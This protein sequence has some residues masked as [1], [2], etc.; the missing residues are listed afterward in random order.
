MKKRNLIAALCVAAVMALGMALAGCSAAPDPAEQIKAD[1]A[2]QF[3]PV[4]NLDQAAIDE[5]TADIEAV[6][7]FET[8][9]IDG[10]QY[11]K[12][13]LAGFDY[14]VKDVTVA[15]DKTSAVATVDVTCKSFTDA[16]ERA[17]ELSEEF[18]ASDELAGMSMDEVNKKIGSIMM[19]AMDE[20]E[21]KTTECAF[22]YRLADDT[23][24]IDGN[25][26]QEIYNAFFA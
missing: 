1:V 10:T 26:E 7:E 8:Y 13:M 6:N 12:S 5:L 3:D 14:E 21:A 20:T 11:V 22:D 24:I 16:A 9:G 17:A 23:W 18:A 19:Q 15:E 4:K 2:A 25:A